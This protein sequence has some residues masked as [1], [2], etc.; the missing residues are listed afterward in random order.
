M[1]TKLIASCFL[2]CVILTSC[3]SSP[4]KGKWQY[5]GG[6]YDGKPKKADPGLVM[7]R[8]YTNDS[9]EGY[10]I[11]S[12]VDPM[13]YAA[14]KYEI[15][16]DSFKVTSTFS[17]QPSQSLGRTVPYTFNIAGDRLTIK[18]VLPGGMVVEEYWKKVE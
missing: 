6:I 8:T 13:K 15:T 10:V 16:N 17:M 4:I 9:Y 11:Q 18:G 12:G 3:T 2:L 1:K 5:D 7:Q 14:G